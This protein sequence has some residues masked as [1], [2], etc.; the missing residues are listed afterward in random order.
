MSVTGHKSESSMKTLI[1]K[2]CEKT[3]MFM[4]ETISEKNIG[5]I[6]KY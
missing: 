4:S 1:G 3:K 5:K 6:I 2:T